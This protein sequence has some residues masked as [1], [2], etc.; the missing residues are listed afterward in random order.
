MKN[1]AATK[2]SWCNAALGAWK[3]KAICCTTTVAMAPLKKFPRK[4]GVDDP[5]HRY[6]LGAVWGDYDNDGWPDLYV[7]QRR[8]GPIFS[9]TQNTTARSKKSVS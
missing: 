9:T 8:Q 6:G 3:A 7:A 5:R 1:S 4:A 2:E